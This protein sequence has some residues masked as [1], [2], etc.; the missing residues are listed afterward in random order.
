MEILKLYFPDVIAAKIAELSFLPS[1]ILYKLEHQY[2]FEKKYA[3]VPKNFYDCSNLQ[4]IITKTVEDGITCY[5]KKYPAFEM[6]ISFTTNQ[7]FEYE[8]INDVNLGSINTVFDLTNYIAIFGDHNT[9]IV[10]NKNTKDIIRKT[11]NIKLWAKLFIENDNII[12]TYRQLT[13]ICKIKN[14]IENNTKIIFKKK[15]LN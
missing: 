13:Y 3:I 7:Y 10:Y 1:D 14:I 15:K 2:E 11:V 9:I 4:T 12:A 6:L 8:I 5:V